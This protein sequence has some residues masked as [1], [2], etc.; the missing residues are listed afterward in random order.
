ME[1]G[2]SR[3]GL[4]ET[5]HENRTYP[6][7]K[8]KSSR[9]EGFP[10]QRLKQPPPGTHYSLLLGL[11]EQGDVTNFQGGNAGQTAR[12]NCQNGFRRLKGNTG[13]QEM[14]EGNLQIL[15]D[16]DFQPRLQNSRQGQGRT[17]AKTFRRAVS[18]E[19]TSTN[20]S[21]EPTGGETPPQQRQAEEDTGS[22]REEIP[23]TSKTEGDPRKTEWQARPQLA[24][25]S[26]ETAP[27]RGQNRCVWTCRG[28]TG[29]SWWGDVEAEYVNHI[30][31]WMEKQDNVQAHGKE[32]HADKKVGCS[33]LSV[34]L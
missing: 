30:E 1:W 2:G 11:W 6:R 25:L 29:P 3:R 23:H 21:Q 16:N 22:R 32:S 20:P 28:E 7:T 13:H 26:R 14:T 24:R 31:N 8:A 33:S 12:V 18:P 10:A 9:P 15:K 5:P 4:E 19:V 34:Q 17:L 27:R